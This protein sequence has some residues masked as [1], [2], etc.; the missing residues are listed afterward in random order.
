MSATVPKSTRAW[1]ASTRWLR[2]PP[3]ADPVD[4]RNAS[5]LQIV[6]LMLGGLPPLMWLFRLL[7]TH[8]PWRPGETVSLTMS[9]T[10]SAWALF[11]LALIRRGRFQWAIRQLLVV[12]AL[13]TFAS[14]LG[15]GMAANRFE[16][17]IQVIWVVMAGLMIGRRALWLMYLCLAAAFVA[18]TLTDIGVG[19]L[20][21]PMDLAIDGLVSTFIF[22]FIAIVVDR[23]VTALRES[24]RAAT[25]RSNELATANARLL[26]E[27]AERERV[28][29]QLIHAQKVEAVGRLAAGIAHD[30][31]HLLTLILG[32]AARG[33]REDD[34]G[35][36]KAALAGVDSAARRAAEVTHKLLNFSR[37]DATRIE[38]FDAGQVLAEMQSMLRQLF[39][40]SIRLVLDLDKVPMLVRMDRAQFELVVLN[41]AANANQAMPDGGEFTLASWVASDSYGVQ[42]AFSDSGHG[43]SADVQRRVFEPFFTTRPAGQGTGIGMTVAASVIAEAGGNVSVDSASGSGTVFRIRLPLVA[44][45]ASVANEVAGL[46]VTP[47]D[48]NCNTVVSDT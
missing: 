21:H 12:A 37:D 43:M 35:K 15:S 27:I 47:I 40:P 28:T 33:P 26:V 29:E 11:C 34:A 41:I 18:G 36:L 13:L 14:Y 46:E 19:K 2:N 25:E 22:L 48:N 20:G 39:D 7:D 1:R 3:I 44:P 24:L 42:I 4:R 23:S 9:L 5:M 16:Q 30:F 31:N 38:V 6:L 10:L 32:Y 8:V 17:P 45:L